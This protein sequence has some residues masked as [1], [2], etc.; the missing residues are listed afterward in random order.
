M[1]SMEQ[2]LPRLAGSGGSLWTEQA[3]R[4]AIELTLGSVRQASGAVSMN[5]AR[6]LLR[7]YRSERGA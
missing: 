4:A 6:A 2:A 7:R 1:A 3:D 5:A